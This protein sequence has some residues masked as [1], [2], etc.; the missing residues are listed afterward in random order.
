MSSFLQFTILGV[1]AG[2]LYAL[3]G[4]GLIVIY[5]GAG[6]VNFA[7]G[8]IGAIGAYVFWFLS[9]EESFWWPIALIIGVLASAIIGVLIQVV[10]M[11]PLR[12]RSN[13]SRTVA[14][15]GILVVIENAVTLIFPGSNVVLSVNSFLST[16]AWRFGQVAVGYNQIIILVVTLVL[17]LV[18]WIVYNKTRFGLATLAAEENGR[19]AAALAISPNQIAA[20]N[21]AIG[22]A[23][24]GLSA[25]LLVPILGLQVSILTALVIPSLAAAVVGGMASFPLT[26]AGGLI[27]GILQ[28]LVPRYVQ[29]P[30]WP[31]AMPFF[32][33][34]VCMV[35]RGRVLPRRGEVLE[36]LPSIGTGKVRLPVVI[37]ISA[38]ALI[39]IWGIFNT[40]WVD[41]VT[42]TMAASVILL[43]SVVV[44]GYAGQLSL[45][46]FGLAGIGGFTAG[47]LIALTHLPFLVC[48]LFGIAAAAAV[49]VVIGLPALR[50]RGVNLAILTLGFAVA[51]QNL[52]FDNI[53][54][55]GGTNGDNIGTPNI[56]GIDLGGVSNP[57][58]YATFALIGFLITALIIAN[59][60]RGT[61]GRRLVAIRNN[62][63]AAA[64]LGINSYGA[65]LYAFA[66][67]G[68]IAAL[69]G[70]LLILRDPIVS[71][72]Q[73]LDVF[74]SVYVVVYAMLG[75][76]GYVAGSIFGSLFQVGSL[77][78][79]VINFLP[80]TPTRN[81]WVQLIGGLA[82]IY[83]LV[84]APEGI[85]MRLWGQIRAAARVLHLNRLAPRKL[86]SLLSRDRRPST[87]I[88]AVPTRVEARTLEVSDVTVRFGGV[89]ALDTVS[90]KVVPGKVL[91][92]I[93]PNGAG[94]TTLIDA[95]TG[96]VSN[97]QGSIAL[98]GQSIASWA[99]R[100]RSRAGVGRSFQSLELF[101]DLTV[102]ENL[103]V[104]CDSNRTTR[105]F[106]DL[107]YSRKRELTAAARTAIHEFGLR[108]DLDRKPSE[109]PYGRRRLVAIARAVAQ[110]PSILLLDEP[111]AGLGDF[112]S[113]ELGRLIRRLV[114]EQ[115][116]GVLLIEHNVD[117]VMKVSDQI[118]TLDFGRLIATG[119]PQE[120]R[121]NQ[122]VIDAYLGV[123]D[124]ELV[125]AEPLVAEI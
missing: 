44:T 14:T 74:Q 58:A 42:T 60:R 25:I 32:V 122:A 47:R 9:S 65:K 61:A 91:G 82:L 66:L 20:G 64:A 100:K 50:T 108:G 81:I 76:I 88:P 125:M 23:L 73:G 8:A 120:L 56:F 63:R 70:I 109:L 29:N 41:A 34:L 30:G 105:Y 55:N 11:S 94:K 5:R 107:V 43:S 89:T 97:Q 111:A 24:A 75:G 3:S 22:S 123:E 12:H 118:V 51:L 45:C 59:L 87:Q 77:G 1:A 49:G 62:E 115:G 4:L 15:L 13:L 33:I 114:D 2:G 37:G 48:V 72:T 104:A 90:I 69:G 31:P 57:K 10:I 46:Q 28:S 83:V 113:E 6:V 71:Y 103:Q 17:A 38:V 39:F 86:T 84:D 99:V 53:G 96:F 78:S 52:V 121:N 80:N 36:R 117:M 7:N 18:L 79:Q 40:T 85:A 68:A 112:E 67:S 95:I 124:A 116:M 102:Y 98:D 19:A 110:Q 35:F 92:V 21:W 27:L 93:G 26:V 106:S 101:E 16:S 119:T 54:I